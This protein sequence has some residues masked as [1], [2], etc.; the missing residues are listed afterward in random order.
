MSNKKHTTPKAASAASRVLQSSDIVHFGD[1]FRR[2][3]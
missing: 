2:T 3:D 1:E